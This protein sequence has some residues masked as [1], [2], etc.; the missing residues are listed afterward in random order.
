MSVVIWKDGESELCEPNMLQHN[1]ANGYTIE[2]GLETQQQAYVEDYPVKD[3]DE[4]EVS[5]SP[6]VNEEELRALGKQYKIRGWHNMKLENLIPK[7]EEAK[8]AG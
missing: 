1:L 4:P 5:E 8:N 2:N 6:N 3:T 7:I